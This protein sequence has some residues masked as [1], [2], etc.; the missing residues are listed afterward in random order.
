MKPV[1]QHVGY[2]QPTLEARSS[3]SSTIRL[4]TKRKDAQGAQFLRSTP[5]A[6]LTSSALISFP[7]QRC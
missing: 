4:R 5:A 7:E 2:A 1:V 6:A 3:V